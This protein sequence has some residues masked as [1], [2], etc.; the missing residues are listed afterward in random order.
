MADTTDLQEQVRSQ[1]ESCPAWHSC[2]CTGTPVQLESFGNQLHA[3]GSEIIEV[4]LLA[5]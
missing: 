4:K 1:Q 2:L 5:Q 3:K